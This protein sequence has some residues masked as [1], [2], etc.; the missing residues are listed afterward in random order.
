M[1][2]TTL[3][4]KSLQPIF[5]LHKIEKA[6]LFGS[7]L[8]KNF[9]KNSDI[10]ILITFEKDLAPLEK[11]ELWW[12]LHDTLREKLNREIDLIIE[13]SLKNPFL[14]EE[15]NKTKQSTLSELP[16]G[17]AFCICMIYSAIHLFLIYTG[18]KPT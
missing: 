12:S 14:I 13:N 18:T 3:N 4:I 7:I 16:N 8:S 10:D 1:K 17:S 15:I 9:N 2:K 6:Y 11:G 5:Q